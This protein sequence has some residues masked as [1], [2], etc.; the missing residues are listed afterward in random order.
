M[1]VRDINPGAAD[2][3]ADILGTVS[4][5]TFFRADDGTNGAQLWISDGTAAGTVMIKDV[6]PGFEAYV[7]AN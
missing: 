2:S 3:N 1:M 5:I 6:W 7:I 4:G